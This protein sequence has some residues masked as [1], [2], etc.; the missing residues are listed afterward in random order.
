MLPGERGAGAAASG[1]G[2]FRAPPGA[3]PRRVRAPE[4]PGAARFASP[5][6]G[7]PMRRGPP[8]LGVHR[9]GT[10]A[11]FRPRAWASGDRGGGGVHELGERGGRSGTGGRR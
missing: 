9:A 7:T 8:A 1:E 6:L 4:V 2:E 3:G 5:C 10:F 11:L